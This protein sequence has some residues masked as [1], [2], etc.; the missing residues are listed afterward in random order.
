MHTH[1]ETDLAPFALATP[2]QAPESALAAIQAG[3][4]SAHKTVHYQDLTTSWRDHY[5][6]PILDATG[7]PPYLD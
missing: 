1:P 3:L 6:N 2:Q 7:R 5:K 4:G